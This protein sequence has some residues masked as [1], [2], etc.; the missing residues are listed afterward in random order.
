MDRTD[1]NDALKVL[2]RSW[3]ILII[4]VSIANFYPLIF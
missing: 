1:I 4:I 3:L 2:N